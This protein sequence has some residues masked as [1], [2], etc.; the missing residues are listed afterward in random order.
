MAP[1]EPV[2]NGSPRLKGLSMSK[3]APAAIHDLAHYCVACTLADGTPVTVRSI[4]SDD[5]DRV[6]SAFSEL[7][8]ESVYTRF[9]SV[10]RKLSKSE[11]TQLT[12]VDFDR[13]VALVLS[14]TRD[15]NETLVG[16]GRYAVLNRSQACMEAEVAFT[17]SPAYRRRGVASLLLNHLMR[18]GRTRGI[19]R[20]RAEV[21]AQN[22]AMLSVFRRTGLPIELTQEFN[23]MSVAMDL[24]ET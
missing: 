21:L 9:F 12:H 10:K 18:I 4:R 19:S 3:V 14:V 1:F 17:T 11:L 2:S 13:V 22:A 23:V 20:F 5:W 8:H 6:L 16:G 24:G 7:D 15:G